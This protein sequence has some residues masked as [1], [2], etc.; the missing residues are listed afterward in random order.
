MALAT[1]ASHI[2]HFTLVPTFQTKAFLLAL[3][4]GV[5]YLAF[6]F[7]E[8]DR[9]VWF[10]GIAHDSANP[11]ATA[12]VAVAPALGT[13]GIR[14]YHRPAF[15]FPLRGLAAAARRTVIAAL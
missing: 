6:D 8:F 11:T 13:F 14:G 10:V 15:P 1:K 3:L 7:N 4:L 5:C 9:F 2:Y 12:I